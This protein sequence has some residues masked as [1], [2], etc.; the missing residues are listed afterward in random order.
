MDHTG[1]IAV[2]VGIARID[3]AKVGEQGY[4]YAVSLIDSIANLVNIAHAIP[5]VDLA[6]FED[7]GVH[8]YD[9]TRAAMGMEF[10]RPP[11]LLAYAIK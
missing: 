4:E 11:G 8:D 7:D 2:E 3:S 6:G 9:V 10:A 1:R 5:S